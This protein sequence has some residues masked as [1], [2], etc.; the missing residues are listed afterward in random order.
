MSDGGYTKTEAWKLQLQG[1]VRALQADLAEAEKRL[2]DLTGDMR[3]SAKWTLACA[4]LERME[5]KR[6]HA[7]EQAVDIERLLS[8][9]DIA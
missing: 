5:I 9:S 7:R 4:F 2:R 8:G 1:Q 6:R 3:S